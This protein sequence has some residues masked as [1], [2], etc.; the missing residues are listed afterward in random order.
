[1]KAA[2]L[3]QFQ[4]EFWIIVPNYHLHSIPGNWAARSVTFKSKLNLQNVFQTTIV[5]IN[6]IYVF[7]VPGNFMIKELCGIE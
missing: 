1:M 5:Q 6:E 2:T 7:S 4:V 3:F